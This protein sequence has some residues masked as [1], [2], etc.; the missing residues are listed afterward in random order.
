MKETVTAQAPEK[1]FEEA[2]ARLEQIIEELDHGELKLEESLRLFEEGVGLA[3]YCNSK[4]DEAQ[5]RVE[6]LLG[7]DGENILTKDFCIDEEE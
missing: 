1:S 3:R 6:L 7:V 5:G 4:L 2:L